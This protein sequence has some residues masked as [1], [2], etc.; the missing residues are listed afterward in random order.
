[1]KYKIWNKKEKKFDERIA[2]LQNGLLIEAFYNKENIPTFKTIYDIEEIKN[3]VICKCSHYID[4]NG[5]SLYEGDIVK[6]IDDEDLWVVYLSDENEW[7]LK[8]DFDRYFDEICSSTNEE[9]EIVGNIYE[10]FN[11]LGD[12]NVEM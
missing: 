11:L 9:L 7:F 3:Y 5:N 12:T 6:V 2:V 1:M 4:K 8:T 10:N